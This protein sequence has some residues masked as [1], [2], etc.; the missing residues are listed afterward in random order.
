[1]ASMM[2]MSGLSV[3]ISARFGPTGAKAEADWLRDECEKEGA[4]VL[5]LAKGCPD[6]TTIDLSFCANI[7]EKAKAALRESHEGIT[8]D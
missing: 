4:T 8:I 1:M 7:T 2:R 6:L 5:A 3:F